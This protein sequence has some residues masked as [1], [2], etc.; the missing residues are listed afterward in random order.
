MKKDFT[1]QYSKYLN[2]FATRKKLWY[3]LLKNSWAISHAIKFLSTLCLGGAESAD[4]GL[5]L[6]PS[7]FSYIFILF[8]FSKICKTNVFKLVPG[9]WKSFGF[10]NHFIWNTLVIVIRNWIWWV[11]FMLFANSKTLIFKN[12]LLFS[13]LHI[14]VQLWL[15]IL[16]ACQYACIFSDSFTPNS[17]WINSISQGWLWPK[18][19]C[20]WQHSLEKNVAMYSLCMLFLTS[21]HV[22]TIYSKSPSWEKYFS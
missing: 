22:T 11:D 14:F 15:Q 16:P 18:E 3:I 19:D 13:F 7:I 6:F 21:R 9:L 10:P 4:I 8:T 12:Q 1:K 20:T 2:T 17:P 5:H